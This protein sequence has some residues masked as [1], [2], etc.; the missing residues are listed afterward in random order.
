MNPYPAEEAFAALKTGLMW[1]A[2]VVLGLIMLAGLG[3]DARGT[4]K[5]DPRQ[6]TL[7]SLHGVYRFEN[8]E[9]VCYMFGSTGGLDC[10]WKAYRE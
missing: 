10:L 1:V 9:V 6:G 7:S 2:L 5:E 4:T 8:D 3:C